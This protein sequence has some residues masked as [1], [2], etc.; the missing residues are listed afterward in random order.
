MVICQ[1]IQFSPVNGRSVRL[2]GD[3]SKCEEQKIHNVIIS[4]KWQYPDHECVIKAGQT[5][6]AHGPKSPY[7]AN[8][9]RPGLSLEGNLVCYDLSVAKLTDS[10]I[11]VLPFMGGNRSLMLWDSLFVNAFCGTAE[12]KDCIALLYRFSGT[13]V[14]TRFESALCSFRNFRRRYDPDPYHVLFVFDVPDDAKDSYDYYMDGKYSL[15]DDIW[16][17]KILEFHNF[18]ID[19]HTGKILFQSDDLKKQLEET[20]DVVLPYKAELHSKPNMLNEIFDADYYAPS[21]PFI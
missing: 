4:L 11:F 15:I 17:L 14:F 13:P 2:T 5:I 6:R 1:D 9:I 18:D 20:L 7:K 10:S 21:K 8:I 3:L 12:D 19:G 16:K